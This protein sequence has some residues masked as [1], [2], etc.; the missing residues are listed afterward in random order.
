V[1]RDLMRQAWTLDDDSYLQAQVELIQRNL[2]LNMVCCMLVCG[3][4]AAEYVELSHNT[5]IWGWAAWM[6]AWCLLGLWLGLRGP[7]IAQGHQL[8]KTMPMLRW[9]AAGLG[10]GW[11]G[12]VMLFMRTAD[13]FTTTLVLSAAAGASAGGLMLFGP[14]WPLTLIFL[15]VTAS[16]V[17]AA[18]LMSNSHAELVLGLAVLIYTV[19]LAAFSYQAARVVRESI[20]LRFE[21]VAEACAPPGSAR[22]WHCPR[23]HRAR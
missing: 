23:T 3:V 5:A 2:T 8:Q 10:G 17:A 4:V 7:Q 21:V 18:L 9:L 22:A 12:L 11:G 20:A 19:F 1:L 6:W 15:T 14:V 13:P 16:P